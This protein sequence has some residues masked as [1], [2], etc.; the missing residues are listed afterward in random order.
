MLGQPQL[1][2]IEGG[3]SQ[4]QDGRVGAIAR[5]AQHML[6][7]ADGVLEFASIDLARTT[8]QPTPVAIR[9]LIKGCFATA[10]PLA[11]EFGL[12]LHLVNGEGAPHELF[13][14]QAALRQAVDNLLGNRLKYTNGGGLEVRM[15]AGETPGGLRIEI[16]D[17]SRG[18][19]DPRRDQ[20]PGAQLEAAP[21]NGAGIGL[22]IAARIVGLMGGTIGH[23][24]D[25]DTLDAGSVFWL[26][27]PAA[28]KTQ[29]AAGKP[30]RGRVL[31]VDDIE[32]NRDV[33]S[34]FLR[35]AGHEVLLAESGQEAVQ[36]AYKKMVDVVLMDVRMPEMDGLEATRR[37]RALPN[38]GSEVP[39]LALS[40]YTMRDQAAQCLQAGMDGFVA[41]PVGYA[42]LIRAIDDVFL[43][44]TVLNRALPRAS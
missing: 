30:A 24:T 22:A 41:K 12:S 34:G 6:E 17:I 2:R 43:R 44:P 8:L 26:E 18:A 16:A 25:G 3:L 21:L 4:Q 39:I 37:I 14:D 28:D 38:P 1:L 19:G 35:A 31:L 33:I 20:T 32:M 15:L 11:T 10:L 27:V 13:T 42:T 29:H 9:D 40:A 7:L 23:H 36:M 5:A